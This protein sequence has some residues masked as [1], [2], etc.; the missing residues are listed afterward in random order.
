MCLAY[1]IS[2]ADSSFAA[3]ATASREQVISQLESGATGLK[4]VLGLDST[5]ARRVRRS[6]RSA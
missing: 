6:I 1:L 2:T 5:Q 4:D 3:P